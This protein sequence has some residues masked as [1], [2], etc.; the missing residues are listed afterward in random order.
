MQATPSLLAPECLVALVAPEPS[1]TAFLS[2]M[3]RQL[4][5]KD[6][7]QDMLTPRLRNPTSMA[8][9][10]GVIGHESAHGSGAHSGYPKPRRGWGL[11]RRWAPSSATFPGAW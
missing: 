2:R 11:P 5:A 3:C 4:S 10:I 9:G 8:V 1:Q 7:G 6:L